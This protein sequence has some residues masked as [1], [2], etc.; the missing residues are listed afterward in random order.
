MAVPISV[1]AEQYLNVVV[2]ANVLNKLSKDHFVSGQ[3]WHVFGPSVIAYAIL[4]LIGSIGWRVID[5]FNWRLEASVERDLARKVHAHLLDQSANFHANR[6]G[7]S[8]VSQTN[9]LLS[10]YVLVA[11]TTIYQVLQL[12]FGIIFT[13]IILAPKAPLFVVFLLAFSVIYI[14]SGFLITKKVRRLSGIQALQKALKLG[15]WLTASA[16]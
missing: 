16:T 15:I 14:A 4:M 13:V 1:L 2:L 6:F 9:K 11:N 3:I 12:I 5:A 7:G 10:S 8:L